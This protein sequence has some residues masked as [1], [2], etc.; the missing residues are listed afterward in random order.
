MVLTISITRYMK[1]FILPALVN[2]RAIEKFHMRRKL[3]QEEIH[4]KLRSMTPEARLR[5]GPELSTMEV[6]TWPWR[7]R[8]P[9]QPLKPKIYQT[10]KT[11]EEVL[12]KNEDWGHLNKRRQTTRLEKIERDIKWA[13]QV[14]EVRMQGAT[15][16]AKESE[17]AQTEHSMEI[18]AQKK[19]GLEAAKLKELPAPSSNSS[20]S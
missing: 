9:K 6:S 17:Q 18:K 15:E 5:I 3:N 11:L 19:L 12:G 8:Q 2:L 14:L 13:R 10:S 1:Q 20:S 16:K 7:I 4:A